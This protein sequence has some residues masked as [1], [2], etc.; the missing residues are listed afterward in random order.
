MSPEVLDDLIGEKPEH[1]LEGN[2]ENDI[3]WFVDYLSDK[4]WK[5]T[6]IKDDIRL[7]DTIDAIYEPRLGVDIQDGRNIDEKLDELINKIKKL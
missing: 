6:V 4:K 5:I 2:E 3:I 7:E 1:F